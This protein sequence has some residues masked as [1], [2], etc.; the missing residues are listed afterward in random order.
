M[1]G[2]GSTNSEGAYSTVGKKRYVNEQLFNNVR[3]KFCTIIGHA[4]VFKKA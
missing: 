2:A 3:Q 1:L 4:S